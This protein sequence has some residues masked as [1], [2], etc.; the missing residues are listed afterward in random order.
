[1]MSAWW[2]SC[3]WEP[4]DSWVQANGSVY[5]ALFIDHAFAAPKAL[6]EDSTITMELLAVQ[7]PSSHPHVLASTVR[8]RDGA[9]ATN[10]TASFSHREEERVEEEGKAQE[11]AK[12]V[13]Y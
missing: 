2:V 8:H 5:R 11:A 9:L 1:M 13:V 3:Q 6:I 10:T 12:A 4:K 7:R